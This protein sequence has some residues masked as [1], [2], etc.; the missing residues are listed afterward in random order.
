M[1]SSTPATSSTNTAEA[2]KFFH[3]LAS[4]VSEMTAQ[5]E[6]HQELLSTFFTN[7]VPTDE[8]SARVQG[9]DYQ[10]QRLADVTQVLFSVSRSLESGGFEFSNALETCKLEEVRARL[11]TDT[12]SGPPTLKN[13]SDLDLF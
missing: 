11:S 5:S 8:L 2:W 1:T 9:L 6:E 4:I 3:N 10:T 7:V 12:T 13:P